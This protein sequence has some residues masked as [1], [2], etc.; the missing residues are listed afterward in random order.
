MKQTLFHRATNAVYPGTCCDV[1]GASVV[2]AVTGD[3]A[4]YIGL[5]WGEH[6]EPPDCLH[7]QVFDSTPE[8]P[9]GTPDNPVEPVLQ[10]WGLAFAH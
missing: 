3:P 4:G 6:P 8:A 7:W 10:A 5:V 2:D 9:D 1:A